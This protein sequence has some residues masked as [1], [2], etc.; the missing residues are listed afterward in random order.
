M[1]QINFS[2]NE[3]SHY[4]LSFIHFYWFFLAHAEN[5]TCLDGK[6]IFA[7]SFNHLIRKILILL[8]YTV[9]R[10]ASVGSCI[11]FM[12]RIDLW[13]VEMC[14]QEESDCSATGVEFP[15]ENR[16]SLEHSDVDEEKKSCP[17]KHKSAELAEPKDAILKASHLWTSFIEQVE[18]IRLSTSLI[19][20]VWLPLFVNVYGQTLMCMYVWVVSGMPMLVFLKSHM[21]VHFLFC[22]G[23]PLYAHLTILYTYVCHVICI[24]ARLRIWV[25]ATDYC[26]TYLYT[27]I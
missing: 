4:W 12:P 10:C 23:V 27:W 24:N 6:L 13:A 2:W 1:Q 25:L 21:Y 5:L 8:I 14:Y 26:V 7:I 18:S 17:N 3:V 20:L 9:V 15:D 16:F 11:V 22:F 19:I